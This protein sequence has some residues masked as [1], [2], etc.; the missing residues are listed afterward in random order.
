VFDWLAQIGNVSDAEMHRTFNCGIGMVVIIDAAQAE[1]ALSTLRAAGESA[2]LI[3]E[4]RRG[5]GG[6]T[7]NP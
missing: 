7:I 6:V 2:Q 5:D 4:V 3:G 1:A